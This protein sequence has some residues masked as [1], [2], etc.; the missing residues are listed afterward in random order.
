VVA[1]MGGLVWGLALTVWL[2]T[3]SESISVSTVT[4]AFSAGRAAG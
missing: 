4:I 2:V 1:L 3:S